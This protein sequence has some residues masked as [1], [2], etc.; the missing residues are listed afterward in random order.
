M[1]NRTALGIDGGLVLAKF[2]L[3]E[4]RY[5]QMAVATGLVIFAAVIGSHA[6]LWWTCHRNGGSPRI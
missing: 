4:M 2:A 3:S 1:Q 6:F 5:T